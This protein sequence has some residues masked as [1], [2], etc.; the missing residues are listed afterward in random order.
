MKNL[1]GAV[2]GSEVFNPEKLLSDIIDKIKE[3]NTM[4]N[5]A[6]L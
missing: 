2:K 3:Y 6:S 5:D 4:A 1:S